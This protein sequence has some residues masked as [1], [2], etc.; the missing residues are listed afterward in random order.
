MLK[1]FGAGADHPMRNPKEARRILEA[2]PA[3]DV[4]ALDSTRA[5]RAL[6]QQIKWQHMRY[7]PVD[8]AVW[9]IFNRVFAFSESRGFADGKLALY[10]TTASETSP[11]QEFLRAVMFSASSP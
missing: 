10:P 2:L 11:R 3:D 9:G 8:P 4:K 7:G 5:L 1:L 6:A